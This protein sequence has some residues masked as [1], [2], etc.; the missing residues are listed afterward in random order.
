MAHHQANGDEVI[1]RVVARLLVKAHI[2]G[3]VGQTAHQ[4]VVAI[5]DRLGNALGTEQGAA[6]WFVL[7]HE[8]LPHL[9]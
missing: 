3:H 1:H 7:H 8:L 4:E 6:A 2:E 9:I 5:R